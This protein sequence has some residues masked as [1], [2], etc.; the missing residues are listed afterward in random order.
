MDETNI[1]V[2]RRSLYLFILP[3]NTIK[4]ITTYMNY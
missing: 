4:Q 2:F 3:T 1:I